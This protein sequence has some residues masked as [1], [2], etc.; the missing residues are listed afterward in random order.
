MLLQHGGKD[1]AFVKR[2]LA[3]VN[4][5]RTAVRPPRPPQMPEAARIGR[6][7]L[8]DYGGAGPP[9]IFVPSLINPPYVLDLSERN[10]LLR[11]LSGQ[12]VRPLLLDWGDPR[13]GGELL[14]VGG[15]IEELLLP[16]IAAIGEEPVLAGYCLGG[17]MVIAAATLRKPRAVLTIASPWNFD[18]FSDEARA[19]MGQLW[20]SNRKSAEALG[21]FPMELLQLAFWRLDP[22]RTLTKYADFGDMDPASAQA[23]GFIALEDWANEGPPLTLA[24]GQELLEDMFS[25]N[26]PGRGEWRVG[27]RTIDPAALDCPLFNIVSSR[28]KIVPAASAPGAGESLI[29]DQGHVGMVVGRG[30]PTG[31]W[32]TIAGWLS[33][34]RHN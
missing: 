27:N 8:F 33:Q 29:L 24:A 10:S 5:Y 12:G 15:H 31:L 9:V 30:A 6:A 7:R 17:T 19:E 13:D 21:V 16:L 32:P 1:A 26:C 25:A 34:V 28:D 18:G 4:A 23:A 14:S 11:W 20:T 3:G 2:V 22:R